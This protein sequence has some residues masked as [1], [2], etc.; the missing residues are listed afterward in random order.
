MNIGW[1]RISYKDIRPKQCFK[2]CK[3]GHLAKHCKEEKTCAQIAEALSTLGRTAKQVPNAS[4][5]QDTIAVAVKWA[6]FL[7]G[8]HPNVQEKIHQE[9]DIALG[10]DSCSFGR[11]SQRTHMPGVRPK[12]EYDLKSQNLSGSGRIFHCAAW[13]KADTGVW[14]AQLQK[15]TCFNTHVHEE[16]CFAYLLSR[17]EAFKLFDLPPNLLKPDKMTNERIS[18]SCDDLP[19]TPKRVIDSILQ[20]LALAERFLSICGC[21]IPKR[22]TVI[23]SPFLVHRDEDVCFPIQRSLIRTDF[24]RKTARIFLSARTFLLLGPRNCMG[25]VFGEMEVKVLVC[26]ILRSFSLHSLDS[27]E[28][29][30]SRDS[31][32]QSS[33]PA[34]IKFRRRQ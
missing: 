16:F 23:V 19:C 1:E 29:F 15:F 11:R 12:E 8:L 5:G 20:D 30:P 14:E 26:H 33:Q 28:C 22:T 18:H 34:R 27:R 25:R 7:I 10:A 13:T 9:L 6:L 31:K 4:T 17:T 32:S 24:Y 2:C 3:F 21:K